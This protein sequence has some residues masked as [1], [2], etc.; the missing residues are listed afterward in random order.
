MDTV[1]PLRFVFAFIFILALIGAMAVVL[2]RFSRFQQMAGQTAE[3]RIRVME[4]RYLDPKRRLVLIR[5]DE[6]EYL[7]LLAD[8]RELVIESRLHNAMMAAQ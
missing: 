1:D 8:G 7:L 6:M 2:K 3:G 4:T 5:K